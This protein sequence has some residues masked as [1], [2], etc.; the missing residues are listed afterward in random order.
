MNYCPKDHNSIDQVYKYRI[1][2]ISG[3][4][5]DSEILAGI[6]KTFKNPLRDDE[7]P[8]SKGR[9]WHLIKTSSTAP[10]ELSSS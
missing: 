7:M 8:T 6:F 1:S 2:Y 4:K 9:R 3:P 10:T 5:S